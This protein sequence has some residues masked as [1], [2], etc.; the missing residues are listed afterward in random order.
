MY[1]LLVP[2]TGLAVCLSIP[3]AARDAER[4]RPPA[5]SI[6]I[7]H[8]KIVLS[9]ALNLLAERSGHSVEANLDAGDDPAFAL[10]LKNATFWQ[11]LDQIA[12]A[13][14]TQVNLYRPDGKVELVRRGQ[15]SSMPVSHAGPFRVGLRKLTALT[16]FSTGART[17]SATLEVAWE[18]AL[19]PYYLET[20]PQKMMLQD[21]Q[22]KAIVLPASGSSW[23]A[24]DGRRVYFFDVALPA[25]PRS[26]ARIGSWSGTLAARGPS[27]M[28]E[29]RFTNAADRDLTLQELY[30]AKG[31]LPKTVSA[32]RNASTCALNTLRL[33]VRSWTLQ[34]DVKLPPEG[35]ELE[36]FQTWYANNEVLLVHRDGKKKLLPARSDQSNAGLRRAVINYHFEDTDALKRGTASDWHLVCRAPAAI[37]EMEIPFVFKDVPL[38]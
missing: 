14:G 5:K 1:G 22:G 15:A 7:V 9:K 12:R 18:P 36:S 16:D 11:A 20:R 32:G 38:P 21:D 8:D 31:M 28:H 29:F 19:E 37:I 4:E 24:V 2:L 35:P 30:D 13:S 33:G 3:C 34:I 10:E 17:A 6:T 25:L 26:A 27:R 23:S